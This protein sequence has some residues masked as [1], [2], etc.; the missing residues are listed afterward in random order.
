MKI[1]EIIN[2]GRHDGNW[3]KDGVEMCS[4]KCCGQPVAEC[5]CGPTCPHCDCYEKNKSIK[6]TTTAGAVATAMGGGN[7][8]VS[9]GP[10]VLKR[11]TPK[12]KLR[13]KKKR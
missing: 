12:K 3:F 6:E 1:N 2:E 5:T 8:F 7:G 4:K 11:E 10:G 13:K 9:G